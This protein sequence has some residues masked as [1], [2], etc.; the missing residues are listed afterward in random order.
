MTLAATQDPPS[1]YRCWPDAYA[2]ALAAC[3][4][5]PATK[6][7]ESFIEQQAL[8]A[9]SDL[10]HL[11]DIA[12]DTEFLTFWDNLAEDILA[13]LK[14]IGISRF[15]LGHRAP[16]LLEDIYQTYRAGYYPCGLR[17][18]GGIVAFDPKVLAGFDKIGRS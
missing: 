15:V 17:E 1:G 6:L 5:N 9:Q 18:D 4:T 13:Q 2:L 11:W 16:A 3:L 14:M 8:Q 7:A 12:P 10:D